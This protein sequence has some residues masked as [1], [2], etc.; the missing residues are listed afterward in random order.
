[1]LELLSH[2]IGTA[3]KFG[4]PI[5]VCGEMAGELAYTACCWHGLAPV[6]D[7]HRAG[8]SIKQRVLITSLPEIAGL[9]QKILRADDPMKIRDLLDKLNA[10]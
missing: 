9:T 8:A 6:F 10:V 4:M 5:S 3:N 2:V 7:E 1:V